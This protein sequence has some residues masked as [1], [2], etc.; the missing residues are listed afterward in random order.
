MLY[1]NFLK[2]EKS[3][4]FCGRINCRT[5]TEKKNAF[6]TYA[7]APYSRD[8]LLVVPK[9]HASSFLGLKKKEGEDIELLLRRG[10]ELLHKLGHK[11]ASVLVRDGSSVGARS[12]EHVHFHIIP[13]HRIGDLDK[14]GN[15]RR[16]LSEREIK[17]LI[18]RIRIFA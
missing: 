10:I 8:H 9:R 2:T 5:I 17:Q 4:P 3:C 7:I 16:V 11:D 18:D 6:M 14:D 13:D 15:K 1:K 12:I